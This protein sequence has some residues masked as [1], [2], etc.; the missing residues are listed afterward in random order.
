MQ[1]VEIETCEREGRQ[2][3]R[4]RIGRRAVSFREEV[5]ARAFAAQLH[6]RLRWLREQMQDENLNSPDLL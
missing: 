4:V 2:E 3:W 6:M 1:D 5:A